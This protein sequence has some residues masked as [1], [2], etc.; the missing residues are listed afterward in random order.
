MRIDLHVHSKYSDDGDYTPAELVERAANKGVNI[1]AIAD[2]NTTNGVNEAIAHSHNVGIE[3]IPAIEIDCVH[4]GT[5]LHVLGYFIDHGDPAFSKITNFYH[6]QEANNSKELV[7]LVENLGIHINHHKL[8]GLER[9]G[10]V[11]GEMIAECS[12]YEPENNH[13]PLL[14]AYRPGGNRS[15][16]PFVNFYWDVCAQGK[17][18]YVQSNY[19]ELSQVVEVIQHS[20]G[21]AVLAHPGLNVKENDHLLKSIL[22]CGVCGLEVYSSY[23]TAAQTEFYRRFAEEQRCC[24]TCGSDFHGKTKPSIEIGWLYVPEPDECYIRSFTDSKFG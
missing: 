6:D 10:V 2:H 3:V 8:A 1:L 24:F 4:Q 15:D 11:T 23:H 12:I 20:G 17:P 7:R 9:N 22:A 5:N 16:N 21:K 19:L 18:A 14:Q 13:Q